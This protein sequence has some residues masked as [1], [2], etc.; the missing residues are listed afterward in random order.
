MNFKMFST[1]GVIL[2]IA[3]FSSILGLLRETLLAAYFGISSSLEAFLIASVIPLTILPAV[4]KSITTAFLPIFLKLK[5]DSKDKAPLF[6][7][8]VQICITIVSLICIL[9]LLI[10]TPIYVGFIGIDE[11]IRGKTIILTCILLPT[12]LFLN[13][14]AL[15]RGL[16]QANNKY[17]LS[18]W[19]GVIQNVTFIT[20]IFIAG[21]FL[22]IIYLGIGLLVSSFLQYIFMKRDSLTKQ[23]FKKHKKLKIN[24]DLS[25]KLFVSLFIGSL[26]TSLAPQV[27]LILT[28]FFINKFDNGGLPSLIYSFTIYTLPV[29]LLNMSVLTILYTKFN[30]DYIGK[31]KENL[32]K[33]LLDGLNLL[34]ILIIPLSI[35]FYLYSKEIIALIFERG[36]FDVNATNLTAQSLK[37]LMICLLPTVLRE[38]LFK[39][40]F[41]VGKTKAAFNSSIIMIIS[42]VILCFVLVPIYKQ[43]GISYAILASNFIVV[44]NILYKIKEYISTKFTKY[45][46][47]NLIV[48]LLISLIIGLFSKKI[49]SFFNNAFSSPI[50]SLLITGV[51]CGVIYL[52]IILLY[53]FKEL[54]NFSKGKAAA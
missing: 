12:I 32:V 10:V 31:K 49:Y 39:F 34:V 29:L 42:S 14:F 27:P 30:E 7:K 46:I 3:I 44:F 28:R 33:N 51:S 38:L 48:I 20:F 5:K 53:K 21:Y 24:Y 6:Y 35:F 52:I 40:C 45:F 22:N 11:N 17:I 2:I 8:N 4:G 18:S 23:S 16:F 41:A 25:F 37:I 13:L 26:V 47:L 50:I 9:L 54:K 15:D 19:V 43:N 36:A 1:S